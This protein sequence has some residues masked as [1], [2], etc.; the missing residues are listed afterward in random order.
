MDDAGAFI[1]SVADP[2]KRT[3]CLRIADLFKTET[4]FDPKLWGASIIGFGSYHYKYESGREGDAPIVGF[5]PRKEAIVLYLS[6][7]EGREQL[8]EKLGKHKTGKGCI[9]LKKLEDV[10]AEVLKKLITESVKH[11]RATYL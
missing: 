7:F 9:Y 4:G 8:L 2:A 5:S 1:G 10:D 3:D 11:T 6:Q